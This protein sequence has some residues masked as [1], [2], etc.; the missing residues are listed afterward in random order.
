MKKILALLIIA[1][2]TV[3]LCVSA[4][5]A[6]P[7]LRVDADKLYELFENNT[8]ANTVSAEK[9]D[10]YV[11]FT[12]AGDDPFFGFPEPLN[13]GVD[14]KY[15][16]VKYRTSDEGVN[17]IDFYLKIAE[18]HAQSEGI[19]RDGEWHFVVM[20]LSKPFPESMDTLWDGTIARF[21]PMTGSVTGKSID[22]AYFE[23]YTSEADAQAATRD[24]A[25]AEPSNPGSGDAAIIAI[26]AV[27]CVALAGVVV[28]KKVK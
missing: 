26:A 5:A 14:A 20:D 8:G 28:A 23:F 6:S 19:V 18:P 17:T 25:P 15:A 13:P 3:A 27:G 21:D 4:A 7:V 22:I 9:K 24:A 2:M 10:G 11:T 12:A 16:V 1:V